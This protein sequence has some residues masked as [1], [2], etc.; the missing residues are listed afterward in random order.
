MVNKISVLVLLT[1]G[2]VFASSKSS[3]ILAGQIQPRLTDAQAVEIATSFCARIGQ[4]VNSRPNVGFP[5]TESGHW[6]P[7][8]HIEFPREA[9]VEVV[10][11]TG[12]ICRYIN[13]ARSV[14]IS[15]EILKA[16]LDQS[17]RPQQTVKL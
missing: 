4:P 13:S 7:R 12:V 8:W 15:Q 10:D 1:C 11:S 5:S 2:A 6:L 16:P 3:S 17:G 14:R 9:V